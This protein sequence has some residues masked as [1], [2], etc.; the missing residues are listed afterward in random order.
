MFSLCEDSGYLWNSFIYV[1]KN[2][3]PNLEE[4]ELERRIGKSG[5]VVISLIKELLG[6][7]Y[8]LFVDNWCTSQSLFDDLYEH[9]TVFLFFFF[10]E[11]EITQK[12]K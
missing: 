3:E 2:G 8:N 10:Y 1:G 9:D 6:C 11:N 5:A 4:K 7:G 12:L